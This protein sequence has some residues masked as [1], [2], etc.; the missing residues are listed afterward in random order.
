M[1][2][3]EYRDGVIY[4]RYSPG[5][6]QNEQSIEGQLRDCERFCADNN[7]R[8]IATYIDRKQSGRSDNRTDFQRM[9]R[10]SKR[11][12]F[13]TVVVWK[14]DR[15]GRNRE[16]IAKN[17]AVLRLNG[18]KV[19]S[20]KEHIPDGPEGIILE[21]V[22]EGLAEYYSANLSQ[23]IVRGMRESALKCQ[24]NGS[25]LSLGYSVDKDHKF[26]IDPHGAAIVKMIYEKYDNGEKIADILRY[27]QASGIKTMKGKEYTHYGISRILRNR[28]YIG[29]YKWQ[30]IVIPDGMP[31][32]ISDEL[33]E[34][35]QRRMEKNKKAPSAGR[36]VD[37]LLTAKLFCGH[38]KSTMIG[39]S[40]T[41]KTGGKWYYYSCRGRKTKKTDCKKRSVPKDWLEREV[42]ALT[43]SYILQDDIISNIAD[44]VVEIQREEHEDNSMLRY[45]EDRLKEAETSIRNIMRAIE[46]G[47]F[48]DS[49]RDRLVELEAEKADME[50]EIA[51]EKITRPIV[52]REQVIYFLNRFKNGDVDDKEYQRQIID[53]LVNKVIL[54]DDKITITYNYSGEGKE[55]TADI[56]EE[57]ADEALSDA[58]DRCSTFQRLVE[59]RRIELLSENNSIQLSPGAICLHISRNIP[60]QT[61]LHCGS[62]LIHDSFKS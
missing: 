36:G 29:E 38:C 3:P 47:V 16:E 10:D 59:A 22:L 1:K 6:N 62:F 26:H 19:L 23:N 61:G 9:L 7:I 25:G 53:A 31:R 50:T 45:Y 21:S 35:V 4:A 44:R 56:I 52:T 42:V 20:A 39:D 12:A 60:R 49:T 24:Y 30:D 48:T 41:G 13:S 5:P 17:K 27:I 11:R 54:Y 14:I 43:A 33:F 40:G 58:E 8:I 46:S 32:I 37:F 51:K 28:A 18:V 15:F 34:R 55:I 2:T 57:A